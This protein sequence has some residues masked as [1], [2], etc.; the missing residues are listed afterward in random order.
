MPWTS[1]EACSHFQALAALACKSCQ[2]PKAPAL[3]VEQGS[4]SSV[5]LFVGAGGHGRRT[6]SHRAPCSGLSL[7]LGTIGKCLPAACK[8]GLAGLFCLQIAACIACGVQPANHSRFTICRERP[9]CQHPSTTV[10]WLTCSGHGSFSS[11]KTLNDV[12]GNITHSSI[13]V[14]YHGESGLP[15]SNPACTQLGL[16]ALQQAWCSA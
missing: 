13:L 5:C 9:G 11:N 1:G 12:V 2:V 16:G 7:L 8:A 14:P 3:S 6:G 10:P 4:K 15:G